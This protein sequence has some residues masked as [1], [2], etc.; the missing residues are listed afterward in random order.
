MALLKDSSALCGGCIFQIRATSP[1]PQRVEGVRG[2]SGW[3]R[4]R[5]DLDDGW[6]ITVTTSAAHGCQ[7]S[8][9]R[10]EGGKG[11]DSLWVGLDRG[12]LLV[13]ELGYISTVVLTLSYHCLEIRPTKWKLNDRDR[14]STLSYS[15]P[16]TL[17]T[18]TGLMLL[19]SI[20]RLDSGPHHNL[21][22]F[23]RSLTS[24]SSIQQ[25]LEAW[26]LPISDVYV[27]R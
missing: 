4:T 12:V 17:S 25:L 13:T 1:V 19:I 18:I 8:G 22:S 2:I 20:P 23:G 21:H 27:V 7:I 15:R 14:N 9:Q 24:T 26:V 6:H 10:R 3:T 11:G 16:S 5:L